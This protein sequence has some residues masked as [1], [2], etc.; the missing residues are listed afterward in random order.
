MKNLITLNRKQKLT[1]AYVYAILEFTFLFC[2]AYS[3]NIIFYCIGAS[4]T[5]FLIKSFILFLSFYK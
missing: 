2:K 4:I 5:I 3:N 1:I